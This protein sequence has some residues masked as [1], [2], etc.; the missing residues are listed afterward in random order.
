MKNKN[1][2]ESIKTILLMGGSMSIP[3]KT[4]INEWYGSLR[5]NK[6]SDGGYVVEPGWENFSDIDDAV[7]FFLHKGYTSNN[8]GYIQTRLSEK[9]IDFERDYDLENPDSKLKKLFKDEAKLVYQEAKAFNII[10][11]E[12]PKIEVAFNEIEEM[13]LKLSIDNIKDSL[14]DF[15]NKYKRLDP[16]ISLGFVYDNDGRDFTSGVEYWMNLSVALIPLMPI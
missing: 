7:N 10:V 12:I 11:K 4:E 8:V 14:L 3:Y 2:K 5:I 16:Y 1:M 15:E 9:G 13:V 6:L